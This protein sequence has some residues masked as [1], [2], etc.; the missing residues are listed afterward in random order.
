MRLKVKH[1]HRRLM[2][3]LS[4]LLAC[5]VWFGGNTGHAANNA[6][7]AVISPQGPKDPKWS[8]ELALMSKAA[9]DLGMNLEIHHANGD[10]GRMVRI[11]REIL[12]RANKPTYLL[13]PNERDAGLRILG[14]A[15][16]AGVHSIMIGGGLS[17]QDQALYGSP[18]EKYNFWI[19]E[20]LSDHERGGHILTK[21]LLDHAEIR[22]LHDKQVYGIHVILSH[23]AD[24][25]TQRR[26]RG[27][28]AQVSERDDVKLGYV[29]FAGWNY[30]NAVKESEEAF[31]SWSGGRLYLTESAYMAHAVFTT[32]SERTRLVAGVDAMIGNFGWSKQT[33]S[34]IASGRISAAVGGSFMTGPAAIVLAHD[35]AQGFDFARFQSSYEI[36]YG[37]A[38]AENASTIAVLMDQKNWNRLDFRFFSQAYRATND[39]YK[40]SIVSL[41]KP[42]IPGG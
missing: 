13:Y 9:A 23:R 12:A 35:H 25:T 18:R 36:K 30:Q 20:V 33:I 4:I 16:R 7:I 1:L 42:L 21:A 14:L 2:L 37:I 6:N 5:L 27:I 15:E 29:G 24:P 17:K 32:L 40:F 38:N 34:A 26:F 41:L 19:G 31:K 10:H 22:R 11:A 8:L 3:A 39:G 28:N